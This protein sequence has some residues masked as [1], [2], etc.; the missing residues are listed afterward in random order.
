MKNILVQWMEPTGKWVKALDSA[1]IRFKA[2]DFLLASE[3]ERKFAIA[4]ELGN[5][6]AAT[7]GYFEKIEKLF[8]LH[9]PLF[10]KE[11]AKLN[12]DVSRADFN[13]AF[14]VRNCLI[15][16]GGLANYQVAQHTE[17]A[18]RENYF[19]ERLCRAPFQGD[20][21]DR[22]CGLGVNEPLIVKT[23]LQPQTHLQIPLHRLQRRNRN[24]AQQLGLA[25]LPIDRLQLKRENNATGT[26]IR[27]QQHFRSVC[28]CR[29]SLM[30]G[31]R[32]H[33][34]Q[35]AGVVI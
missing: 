5:A 18:V 34:D 6:G 12:L 28:R 4:D 24:A 20:R 25:R 15:H 33:H 23:R 17:F 7:N 11:F 30:R 32:T 29:C 13:T 1:R 8:S 21:R 16:D 2:T 10:S 22:Q 9:L 26:A 27:R 31:D 19:D 35:F 14:V 3:R